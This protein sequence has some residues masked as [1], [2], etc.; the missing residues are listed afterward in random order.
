MAIRDLM[1]FGTTR[2]PA[3]FAGDPFEDMQRQMNRLFDEM[4]R[5]TPTVAARTGNGPV[6]TSVDVS[7]TDDAYEVKADLP[8]LGKD[9]V[10]VSFADGILTIRGEHKEEKAEEEEGRRYHVRERRYASYQRSFNFG[11]AVDPNAIKADFADG[12]LTVI[13]PK[14]KESVSQVKKIAIGS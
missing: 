5:G 10:D 7:E 4:W 9:E 11:A 13:L 14:S 8:G 2:Q 1:P 6:A 3:A 12:V